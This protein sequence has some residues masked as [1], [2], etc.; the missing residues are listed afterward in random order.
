M[1]V[2]PPVHLSMYLLPLQTPPPVPTHPTLPGHS[3]ACHA[4]IPPGTKP[5]G[6]AGKAWGRLWGG[7]PVPR[8]PKNS[9]R[10]MTSKWGTGGSPNLL[11]AVSQQPPPAPPRVSPHVTV[12]HVGVKRC[13]PCQRRVPEIWG[14]LGDT[15]GHTSCGT[16]TREGAMT[17]SKGH[18]RG[19]MNSGS[20]GR[21]P[22]CLHI[23]PGGESQT[24]YAHL[25]PAVTLPPP[26]Y[27][28]TTHKCYPIPI[29]M[30]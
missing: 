1:P 10:S 20:T 17:A 28:P 9:T 5:L 19:W 7:T 29:R 13:L 27:G 25:V 14:W 2:R 15:Q 6:G 18:F 24:L 11:R 30:S 22:I 3:S 8:T 12:L 26:S 16:A 23:L 4:G 21:V